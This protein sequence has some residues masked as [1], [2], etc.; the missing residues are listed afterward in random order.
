MHSIISG[1][2]IGLTVLIGIWCVW[3]ENHS[4]D[5][6]KKEDDDQK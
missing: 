1:I 6:K 2:I 4:S 3:Y 5:K